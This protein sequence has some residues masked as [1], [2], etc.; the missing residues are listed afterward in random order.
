MMNDDN[1]SKTKMM[2]DEDLGP[3]CYFFNSNLIN[4]RQGEEESRI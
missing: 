1:E 3:K 4:L 2:N